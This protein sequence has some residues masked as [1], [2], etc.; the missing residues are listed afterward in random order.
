MN[1][2]RWI[3]I[4]VSICVLQ[5]IPFSAIGEANSGI[6]DDDDKTEQSGVNLNDI[7]ITVS[8]IPIEDLL[9]AAAGMFT[10]ALEENMGDAIDGL[11]GVFD[12]FAEEMSGDLGE[13]E[14]ILGSMIDDTWR[15]TI[16]AASFN[17][18]IK[19]SAYDNALDLYNAQLSGE[20]G[21]EG[22]I[23]LNST[24]GCLNMII[25]I[26]DDGGINPANIEAIDDGAVGE[27]EIIFGLE[28]Y[29]GTY[30]VSA[31]LFLSP[32]DEPYAMCNMTDLTQER[33]F[34]VYRD[35]VT[36]HATKKYD[37]HLEYGDQILTIIFWNDN[38]DADW[39]TVV[40]KEVP[41]MLE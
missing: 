17:T 11:N 20:T 3:A 40:A 18:V 33:Q 39:L 30:A 14:M 34:E 1:S 10:E 23:A 16:P 6:S 9:G 24:E 38:S 7:E 21:K 25:Y 4:L 15:L 5:L 31:V 12:E 2:K 27:R 41:M 22:R 28:G 29:T 36:E 26:Y 8:G 13:I 37:V 32:S 35:Y 19:R